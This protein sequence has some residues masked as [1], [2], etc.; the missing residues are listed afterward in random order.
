[1]RVCG[2]GCAVEENPESMM[3]RGVRQVGTG[4]F[5]GRFCW[6]AGE[7][8]GG[9]GAACSRCREKG[10]C[11][12]HRGEVRWPMGHIARC[13]S[14]LQRESKGY[15]VCRLPRAGSPRHSM[16]PCAIEIVCV[17]SRRV[18]GLRETG[19]V[20]RVLHSFFDKIMCGNVRSRSTHRATHSRRSLHS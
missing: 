6:E 5:G 16:V 2:C 11:P 18:E 20:S 15:G 14:E 12:R 4:M 8:A 1:M 7:N 17:A 10:G 19:V 9:G 13:E 3:P